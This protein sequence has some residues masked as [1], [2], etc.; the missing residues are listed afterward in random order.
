MLDYEL[1]LNYARAPTG[2]TRPARGRSAMTAAA[3]RSANP[4]PQ[5]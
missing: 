5:A 4:S 3:N 2:N 1:V